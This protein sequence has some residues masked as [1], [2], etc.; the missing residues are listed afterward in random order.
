MYRQTDILSGEREGNIQ[1]YRQTDILNG[2]GM[3][4]LCLE[5]LF[6]LDLLGVKNRLIERKKNILLMHTCLFL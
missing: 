2:L 5:M 4:W 1:M 3:L 6:V